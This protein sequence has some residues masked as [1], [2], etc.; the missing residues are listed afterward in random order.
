[1]I[2]PETGQVVRTTM[3]DIRLDEISA[4]D[5]PAQPGARMS[6][7]KRAAVAKVTDEE[8]DESMESEDEGFGA[9]KTKKGDKPKKGEPGY[10]E[11]KATK[12]RAFLTTPTDGHTHLLSDEVGP[13]MRGAAGSTSWEDGHSH[14]WIMNTDT[15]AITI[16]MV[17]GHT[18][19]I[20]MNGADGAPPGVIDLSPGTGLAKATD[21][22]P[23]PSVASKSTSGDSTADPV[24]N[25]PHEVT[26]TE[27]NEKT[28]DTDQAAVAKQLEEVTKRA[29]RAE[30]VSELSDAQRGI[31]KSLDVE[32]QDEFLALTPEQR[33][34]EVAKAAE[35]NA[36][37]FEDQG[38]QYR[39]NDDP[40]L[41]ALAKQAKLE[42]EA[43]V[44]AEKRASESDLRKRAEELQHIPGDVATR[45][46]MLKGIDMLPEDQRGPAL[47]SLKAQDLALGEA[48]K[49]A[50]T[51]AV[52]SEV[53]PL[54]SIAK[55]LR[56]ADPS[57]TPEQAMAKA[58]ETPEGEA[59][60][61]KSLGL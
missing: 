13:D 40:R 42:R 9:K 60:Y 46:N 57:L 56:E 59:A 23:D 30:K 45:M 35:A 10:Q 12:K 37:V 29:E 17:N 24:G 32:K 44:E 3:K 54:D 26:M 49:R 28:V 51:S 50:G 22:M 5:R 31:F 25:V 38:V 2:D 55:T 61:A 58:L 47:E 39:K 20:N 6:I 52:P 34:A 14:P 16:G 19:E 27:K 7:M 18:H 1:M 8:E 41:I 43:R 33:D 15:G 4:V 48:F 53:N 11:P 21:G 36:V